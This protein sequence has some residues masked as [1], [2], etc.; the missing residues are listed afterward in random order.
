MTLA[1]SAGD[2]LTAVAIGPDGA[3]AVAGF[4]DGAATLG[5]SSVE[6][7]GHPA[8]VVARLDPATGK[9]SWIRAI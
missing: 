3:I 1:G 9:P 6:G 7:S 5:G 2:E 4:A 8:A